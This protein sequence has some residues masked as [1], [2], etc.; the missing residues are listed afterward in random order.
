MSIA[1]SE[2]V[3]TRRGDGP[4]L[5]V[6]AALRALLPQ[7]GLRRGS[8]LTVDDDALCLGLAAEASAAGGW[9]AVV[10]RPD[11]GVL[12]AVDMGIDPRRLLLV[13]DPGERWAEVVAALTDGVDV[14]L[15]RPTAPP[16][17]AL[18]RRLEAVARRH[19]AALVV[20]GGWPGADL[21]LSVTS[22]RWAGLR[23]GHGLLTGRR[24]TVTASGRGNAGRPRTADLWLPGADG[25]ITAAAPLSP[26]ATVPAAPVDHVNV[27][28]RDS[29]RR[30]TRVKSPFTMQSP[31]GERGGERGAA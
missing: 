3:E 1:L 14:V 22:A 25:T 9:T 7:G 23:D 6:P 8:V 18:A 4:V 5:P 29:T 17:P 28:D 19:G 31:D 15:A 2:A 24:V 11:T 27:I 21:R 13:D 10:G 12:A 26:A 30:R 20:T 16:A